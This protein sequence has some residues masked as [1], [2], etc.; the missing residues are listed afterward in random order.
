MKP[1]RVIGTGIVVWIVTSLFAWLTCGWLFKWIY[2][3]PPT[4]LWKPA[5]DMMGG[6]NM[7]GMS[8]ISLIG[9]VMF[10][11]VYAVV[12]KGIPGKGIKKGMTYGFLVWLV[13][14]FAGMTG[15]VFY[16]NISPAV[17]VY[18]LVQLFI[19]NQ[20]NGIVVARMYKAK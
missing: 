5:A 2:E 16:M 20:I 9:A 13:G 4:A 3:L 17:V 14:P 19:L 10:V 11:L 12:Y 1:G 8:I 7:A 6:A 18:W 15:M